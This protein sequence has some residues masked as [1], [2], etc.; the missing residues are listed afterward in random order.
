MAGTKKTLMRRKRETAKNIAGCRNFAEEKRDDKNI[1][2]V[3]QL[4]HGNYG[5]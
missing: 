3:L 4:L 1:A 2:L 5:F